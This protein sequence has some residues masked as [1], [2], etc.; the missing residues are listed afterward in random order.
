MPGLRALP[1]LLALLSL[2]AAP[3]AGQQILTGAGATFPYPLYSNWFATYGKQTG[4]RINYQSIGSGGGIRQFIKG[5][6]DFGASDA[7]MKDEQI[8]QVNGNVEQLPTVIGSVVMTYSLKGMGGRRLRLDA[9]TI[10]DIYLGRI[11]SWQDPRLKALNPGV[12]FPKLDIVVVGR[13][14]GSGTTFVFTDYLAKVS[15]EWARRVGR[16]TAVR[17]PVG[18]GGKGNEGVTAQVKLL[19]GSIGYV[20]MGYALANR[21]S[22]AE[23]KNQ[24]GNWVIPTLATAQA[25][26]ASI[27]WAPD[28][29][30]RVSITNAP[31]ANAYPISS[32][33]W[34]L[35]YRNSTKPETAAKLRDFLRWMLT[36]AAQAQAERLHY[37][38]L[39]PVV[40]KLV[41]ARLPVLRANGRPIP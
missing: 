4:V 9:T 41:A 10:A 30:F 20:E 28:T 38:P 26:A 12:T 15:P 34:L 27:E 35:I 1:T 19:E 25:A 14:D 11:T 32:F 33:T 7:S 16:G 2:A 24:A 3:V 18:L 8:A 13:S 17:W 40:A 21:L 37:A 6:V 31:G 39:P 23:L 36:P 5:T 22:F 29:D